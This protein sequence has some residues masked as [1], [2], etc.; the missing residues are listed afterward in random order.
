MAF[1]EDKF[2]ALAYRIVNGEIGEYVYHLEEDTI[3]MF[4]DGYWRE[5]AEIEFLDKIENGLLDNDKNKIVT[6]YPI[7]RRKKII[8]NYKI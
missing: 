3:Y 6:R 1:T 8:E 5:I 2:R 7:E 4:E